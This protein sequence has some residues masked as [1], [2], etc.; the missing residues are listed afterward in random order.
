MEAASVFL[1]SAVE[2]RE[3]IKEPR[4]K[5]LYAKGR[6]CGTAGRRRGGRKLWVKE[7]KGFRE[8]A[9]AFKYAS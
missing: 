2:V 7:N 3:S 6:E 5:P 1:V 4:N 8:V 9:W